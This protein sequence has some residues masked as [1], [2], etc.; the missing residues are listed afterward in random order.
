MLYLPAMFGA[1]AAG[2]VVVL[3]LE[4]FG[5][6]VE[7]E[8]D[9]F[10]V[11]FVLLLILQPITEASS[12]ANANI[13]SCRES[14]FIVFSYFGANM[15]SGAYIVRSLFLVNDFASVYSWLLLSETRLVGLRAI[16]SV[17]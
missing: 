9:L 3:V 10:E 8:F 11:E 5:L 13:A 4:F 15:N 2:V 12:N 16:A 7:F 14:L 1:G 6:S 17:T